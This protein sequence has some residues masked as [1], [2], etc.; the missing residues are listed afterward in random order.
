MAEPPD[1]E[2]RETPAALALAQDRFARGEFA[3]A[4]ALYS[5]FIGQCSSRGSKCSPKDL[6]TAYNNRG[7][8]K[9][10]SV[11]FYEAMDDYTSA[12]EILP[13]FEVPYYNRGLIRYR[14]GYFDEALEDFKKAL[15]LNPEFQDAVLSFKQTILDKEEK[16][17]RNA[18]K[19]TE[20][21][22]L[23]KF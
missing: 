12:I 11:D 16:Q 6:A 21:F 18:E 23:L 10:F 5:A 17:R 15:D 14:L 9:Y 22:N 2:S 19:S 3:E 13:N 20:T 1:R 7:Q 8:T 4:Q